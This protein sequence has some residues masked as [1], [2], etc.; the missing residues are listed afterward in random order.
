MHLEFQLKQ[1]LQSVKDAAESLKIA[2]FLGFQ[3]SQAVI[4]RI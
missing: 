2:A 4:D 3:I 1:N